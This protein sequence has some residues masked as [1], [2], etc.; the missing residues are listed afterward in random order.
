MLRVLRTVKRI[1]PGEVYR[2][3]KGQEEFIG[4]LISKTNHL[5]KDIPYVLFYTI[6]NEEQDFY[7]NE[8]IYIKDSSINA[9]IVSLLKA[10]YEESVL[11][12]EINEEISRL[13]QKKG[14]SREKEFEIAE[15]LT[16]ITGVH[17]KPDIREY[18]DQ[19]ME[20]PRDEVEVVMET[21]MNTIDAVK[22]TIDTIKQTDKAKKVRKNLSDIFDDFYEYID[23]KAYN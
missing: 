22:D 8:G 18:F 19:N 13:Y 11:I 20:I 1:E 3:K 9:E 14:L 16:K 2:V 6:H 10:Y 12:K 23:K 4:V 21:A 15:C 7:E 17:N 5:N